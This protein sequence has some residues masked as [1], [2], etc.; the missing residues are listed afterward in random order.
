MNKDKEMNLLVSD[1][2][3]LF[4]KKSAYIYISCLT[5]ASQS[6]KNNVQLLDHALGVPCSSDM[7]HMEYGDFYEKK[8]AQNL[9]QASYFCS[10]PC[11]L[12]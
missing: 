5:A 12:D 4:S 10:Y 1:F 3:N 8:N 6:Q 2:T 9:K 11:Y 7:E